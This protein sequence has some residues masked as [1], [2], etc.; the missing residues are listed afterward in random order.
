MANINCAYANCGYCGA[1]GGCY[2][3]CAYAN[4][5]GQ[6]IA[7]NNDHSCDYRR[8][9]RVSSAT[10]LAFGNCTNLIQCVLGVTFQ[11]V[12]ATQSTDRVCNGTVRPP[13]TGPAPYTSVNATYSTDREC[14]KLPNNCT[15]GATYQVRPPNATVAE[16]GRITGGEAL[17]RV[18]RYRGPRLPLGMR[19]QPSL[20]AEQ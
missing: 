13:C 9:Y 1:H 10:G 5:E 2:H 19:E 3:G 18:P 16:H 6:A 17:A 7:W 8:Q 20:A 15:L 12:A 11:T 14:T 4:T